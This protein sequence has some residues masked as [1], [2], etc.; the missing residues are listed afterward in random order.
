MICLGDLFFSSKLTRNSQSG[1][2]LFSAKYSQN[3]CSWLNQLM[4]NG[5][6]PV[7][8]MIICAID[9]E[10]TFLIMWFGGGV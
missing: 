1:K 5:P 2:G 8:D 10:N 7:V 6:C 3:Y 4:S 9:N